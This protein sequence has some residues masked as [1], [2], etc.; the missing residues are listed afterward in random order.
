MT[1]SSFCVCE[2]MN[3]VS[4]LSCVS[5]YCYICRTEETGQREI[6]TLSDDEKCRWG[7][8]RHVKRLSVL[9]TTLLGA[10]ETER[11]RNAEIAFNVSVRLFVCLSAYPYAFTSSVTEAT[12]LHETGCR[13]NL[14][15]CVSRC[16][17]SST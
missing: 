4:F 1:Y 16:L 7:K 17:C 6:L 13:E 14:L 2:C 11:C 9:V 5:N 8:S 3:I 10:F 12:V 15:N